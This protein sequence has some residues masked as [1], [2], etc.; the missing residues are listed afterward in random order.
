[1]MDQDGNS[2]KER[3]SMLIEKIKN[4]F[5]DDFLKV[6]IT[7]AHA[8]TLACMFCTEIINYEFFGSQTQR[9]W[10]KV[11]EQIAKCQ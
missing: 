8:R 5:G 7:D 9:Y 1:M 10:I 6:K 3:A 4:G 11:K 2:S